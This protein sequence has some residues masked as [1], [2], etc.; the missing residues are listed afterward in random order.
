MKG[1]ATSPHSAIA[2]IFPLLAEVSPRYLIDFI[3]DL[4]MTK[5][6]GKKL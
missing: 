1:V 3:Y 4:E 5:S 2:S 6:R